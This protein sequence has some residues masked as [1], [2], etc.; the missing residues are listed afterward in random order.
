MKGQQFDFNEQFLSPCNFIVMQFCLIRA[1]TCAHYTGGEGISEIQNLMF[2][3]SLL[4]SRGIKMYNL[5]T[6]RW[7]QKLWC[8]AEAVC[9]EK[10]L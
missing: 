1:S 6:S 10:W 2:A 5:G 8:V 4:V 3:L 7:L 9:M